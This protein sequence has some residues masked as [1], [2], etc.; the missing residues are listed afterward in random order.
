MESE[1][2]RIL[3]PPGPLDMRRSMSTGYGA[4]DPGTVR[5]RQGI[6]RATHTPEGSC[7]LLLQK[8]PPVRVW[9]WGP[10]AE[11]ALAQVTNWLGFHDD[12]T[13]LETHDPVVARAKRRHPGLRMGRGRDI[14]EVLLS[15]ILGQRVKTEEA[16]SSWRHLTNTFGEKSHQPH[17]PKTLRVPPRP[18]QLKRISL[19]AYHRFG[20]E[21]SRAR[22]ML[23]VC[24]HIR[25][26]QRAA[27][28]TA[29]QAV[30]HLMKLPGVGPWT[31]MLTVAAVHGYPDAVPVGDY[32]IPNVVAY[33][34]VGE[35]RAT[36]ER[37]LELLEPYRGQRWR[38]I[39][40]LGADAGT[41]LKFGPKRP[42]FAQG[43][44]LATARHERRRKA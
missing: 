28:M 21:M 8:G 31:A 12:P 18:E 10:G 6:W 37:M 35:A 17:A 14:F 44:A 23:E 43:V 40:L 33:A 7:T 1:P 27:A 38:V 15:T 19:P 36:D 30:P 11:H 9:G 2:H 16:S 4:L 32:H 13:L 26:V 22:T 5:N 34:M 39:R 20:I 41:S 24:H 3:D 29:E 42:T 25:Y